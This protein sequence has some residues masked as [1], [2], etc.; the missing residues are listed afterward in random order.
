MEVRSI[1]CISHARN[2]FSAAPRSAN[3]CAGVA[4]TATY[5]YVRIVTC[6]IKIKTVREIIEARRFE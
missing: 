3:G 6:E 4:V 1:S 5:A 2:E